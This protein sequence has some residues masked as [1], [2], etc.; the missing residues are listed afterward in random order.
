MSV[1]REQLLQEKV[2][3]LRSVLHNKVNGER[4]MLKHK[5]VFPLSTQLDDAIVEYMK[6][7]QH[8]KK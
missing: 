8:K 1:T 2:E 6:E 3:K 5:D 7:Q 4:D